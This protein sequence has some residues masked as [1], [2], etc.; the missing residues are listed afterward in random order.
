MDTAWCVIYYTGGS[1]TLPYRTM[2]LVG[3]A[4]ALIV[5]AGFGAVAA[6][7]HAA[8]AAAVVFGGIQEQ[9]LTILGGA[10]A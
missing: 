5:E 6:F 7:L 1:E 10:L 2:M 3:A 8:P 4:G 9:P